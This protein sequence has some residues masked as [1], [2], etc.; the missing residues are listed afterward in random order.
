MSDPAQ[1][2]PV[3]PSLSRPFRLIAAS[4]AAGVFI[5]LRLLQLAW[6][7]PFFDELFTV[8]IARLGPGAMLEALARDSGPPLYYLV[9]RLVTAGDPAVF[10]ARLVSLAAA[11][12]LLALILLSRRLGNAAGVAA[13][14]L[15]VFAPHV[16]FSTEARAYALAGALAGAGCLALAGWAAGGRRASLVAG[17]GLLVAAGASHYYGVLFFPI[18]LALGLLARTRRPVLEGALASAAAGLAFLPGFL[19][20]LRQPSEAIAWM[21]LV[22][23]GPS[24]LD[25]LRQLAFVADYP[26]VFIAPPPQGLHLAALLL[27]AVVVAAGARSA[28]A[29]RWGVITLVPVA[30]AVAFG[31]LGWNVYFPVRFEAVVAAPLVCWLAVSLLGIPRKGIRAALT[32]LLLSGG[33]VSS[34]LGIM[35][36]LSKRPDPWR[37]AASFVHRTIPESIPVVASGYAYLEVLAQ[38]DAAWKPPVHG[39]PRRIEEHPGWTAPASDADATSALATL[40]PLPFVWVGERSSVE[41][42]A[43]VRAYRLRPLLAGR[44]ILV[45]E[46]T[47]RP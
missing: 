24:P 33:L 29:R 13:L 20:A 35:T 44:G 25:P 38:R 31:A 12:A 21:R 26:A 43:L 3:E 4:A 41:H 42:R 22:G 32:I 27:T 5:A 15:A 16:H 11:S 39:F 18:P 47:Q 37:E 9:V 8:W 10:S 45:A 36:S 40:P 46:A 28:E 14:L 2:A 7:P 6:R 17:T 34:Y 1:T 23:R 30:L 19:L